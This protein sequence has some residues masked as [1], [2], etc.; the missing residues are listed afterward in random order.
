MIEKEAYKLLVGDNPF[1]GIS[2]L[3]QERSRKRNAAIRQTE[4]AAGL[5][6]T[7]L[8]NGA[9]GFMFSVS[10][11]TL[12]ILREI[13]KTRK[14]PSMELYAIVPYAYEYVRLATKVGGIPGLAKLMIKQIISSRNLRAVGLG[15]QAAIT[16]NPR[17]LMKTYILYE[18]SR[19]KSA[20]GKSANLS[21]IVLHELI[22]EMALAFSLDW[23][24]KSY[25]DFSLKLGIK[26]GFETRNFPYL[27]TKF[28]DW[29]IDFRQVSIVT[30]FNKV[31]FLMNPSQASCEKALLKA[32]GGNVIAMSLLAGGYLKPPEAIDYISTLPHLNGVV[33]GVSKEHHARESFR[34]L[35]NK[36]K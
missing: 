20:F 23:F 33:V 2:H 16:M 6:M 32:E 12:S 1:H 9:D 3:A 18:I 8:E 13:R 25:I 34:L 21:S 36:L 27:V 28:I 35:R 5:V 17:T 26:P 15:V 10:E 7:A 4:Y 19:V 31:G 14:Y 30:A 11:T 24:F 22:T 29:G